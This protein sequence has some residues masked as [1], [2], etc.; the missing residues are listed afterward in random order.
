MIQRGLPGEGN[1]LLFD[2]G[3]YGGYSAPTPECPDVRGAAR[4]HYSRVLEFNPVTLEKVWE[5]VITFGPDNGLFMADR[6]FSALVSS[7]Q[8]LPNGNTLITEGLGGRIFEVAPD[9][10]TV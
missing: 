2:N 9:K 6:F 8:R 3:G 1:I 4:R 10:R 7:A 5:Y